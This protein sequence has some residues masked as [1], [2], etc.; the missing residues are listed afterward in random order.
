LSTLFGLEP[1]SVINNIMLKC[2]HCQKDLIGKY[3]LKF[4][5]RSCS[6]SHNN[7]SKVKH[8][9]YAKKE[10]VVCKTLTLAAKYCSKK[11][12]GIARRKYSNEEEKIQLQ[13]LGWREHNANYRAQLL[14]QTPA[15]ADR[16]A[17][18]EFYSKCPVGYDVDHI[19]PISKG[20][21]HTLSNLQYLTASENR[22][23]GNKI[24]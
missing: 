3:T 24:I 13:R 23:K 1:L 4:C 10:C 6:A 20:G 18:K 15:D 5:S 12:S 21:L 17:I 7:K 14:K 8:G 11:C 19:I 22:S 16:K 9:K 2:I